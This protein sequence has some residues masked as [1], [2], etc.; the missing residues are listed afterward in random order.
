MSVQFKGWVP[1]VSGRLSLSIFGDTNHPR[2]TVNANIAD[3]KTRYIVCYQQRKLL[4]AVLP[5][6][7]ILA[8]FVLRL[9]GTFWC[10]CI[11]KCSNDSTLIEDK[12]EGRLL[13]FNGKKLWKKNGAEKIIHQKQ[14]L[15][16]QFQFLENDS[17]IISYY[18]E[19]FNSLKNSLGLLS[20]FYVDFTMGRDGVVTFTIPDQLDISPDAPAF[21]EDTKAREHLIHVVSSQ[22]FFFLRDIAHRHQHHDPKTNTIVDLYRVN[23]DDYTW[24]CDTL[25][26]LY[27]K[28]LEFKRSRQELIY[29]SSLGMLAYVNSFKAITADAYKS[30]SSMKELRPKLNDKTLTESIRA[31]QSATQNSIQAQIRNSD[32]IRNTIIGTLGVLFTLVSLIR[33]TGDVVIAKKSEFLKLLAQC[34]ITYPILSVGV[35][36]LIVFTLLVMF[37]VIDIKNWA[38]VRATV[39]VIQTIPIKLSAILTLISAVSVSIFVY[40]FVFY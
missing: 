34:L 13:I 16:K 2:T 8:K 7:N 10:S 22:L 26:N 19:E 27:R 1:T 9:E 38:W 18:E 21:P 4:D 35:I 36:S 23:G 20:S 29:S 33:L 5:F 12:L 30:Q 6:K 39:K 3:G 24:R 17:N 11:A 25:R 14:A 15:L 31:S 37:K 40:W 28:I 32:T